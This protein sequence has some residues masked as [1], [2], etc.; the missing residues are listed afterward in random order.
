MNCKALG[1][2]V[3]IID[4]RKQQVDYYSLPNLSRT[5]SATRYGVTD[6]IMDTPLVTLDDVL[7]RTKGMEIFGHV[8]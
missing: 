1:I 6:E 5:L 2:A 3:E 4:L 7:T 8:A